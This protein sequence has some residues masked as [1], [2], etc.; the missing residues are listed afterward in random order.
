MYET[1]EKIIETVYAA[2]PYSEQIK[3]LDVT[4][5]SDA[6]MFDWRGTRYKVLENGSVYEIEGEMAS[7]SDIAILM[8]ELFKRQFYSTK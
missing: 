4:K 3:N 5:M 8:R 1:K 7:G 2:L 6:I